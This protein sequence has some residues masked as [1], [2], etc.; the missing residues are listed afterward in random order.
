MKQFFYS[1]LLWLALALPLVSNAQLSMDDITFWVGSGSK[2]A[3]LVIDFNDLF[4]P[5]CYA[6][7]YRFDGTDVTAEKMIAD[8]DSA[9]NSLNVVINSG[10]ISDITY[11][12]HVAI[13]GNPYYFATFTGDGDTASW[14]TNW[15]ISEILTD[16]VWFG[17]SYTDWDT[18]WNPIFK[19]EVP[20]AANQL[21]AIAE[22]D[23]Y[24]GII[25]PNLVSDFF[26][27]NNIENFEKMQI[28][29]T[30]GKLVY[31][32]EILCNNNRYNLMHV[33]QGVYLVLFSKNNAVLHNELIIKE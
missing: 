8:I 10:F 20:V 27:V 17:L 11:L 21:T 26:M 14:S 4:N 33:K 9:D 23:I 13:G 25:Y 3:V 12:N 19:P 24:K 18:L 1:T 32:T 29:S 6:W 7:G 22:N 16:S 5:Q 2:S 30:D 15:G 31:E 28:Y